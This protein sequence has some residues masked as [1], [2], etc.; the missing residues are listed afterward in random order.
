M[1]NYQL[2]K[3]EIINVISLAVIGALGVVSKSFEKYVKKLEIDARVEIRQKRT[4][5]GTARLLRKV[6]SLCT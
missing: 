4:L 5:Q 3:D 2:L 6:L 1:E